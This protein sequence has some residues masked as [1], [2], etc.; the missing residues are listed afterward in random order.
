MD[1]TDWLLMLSRDGIVEAVDGGAP[2]SWLSRRVD[3]CAGLPEGVRGAAR[4]LVRDMGQPLAGTLLRR[5]R[6]GPEAP[7]APSFTLVAVEAILIRPADVSVAALV[8]RTLEPLARQA[9]AQHV[10]LQVDVTDDTPLSAS[11]DAEKVAWALSA[12]VGNALRYVRRGDGVMPGGNI[13]VR[14]ARNG[15][16]R[17]INV[18]VQDDGPGIPA[19]VRPWLFEP[20]PEKGRTA[21]LGLRL[22][23]EIVAAHGGGMVI[24]SSSEPSERGTTVT[25]WLPARS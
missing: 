5:V 9:A 23:H 15:A 24:K 14:A 10:S 8:R 2:G 3:D 17:M 20:D 18:T 16:Q 7:G 19:A 4:K 21:G 22:V 1:G 12:V 11:L 25:L 13:R 6:V